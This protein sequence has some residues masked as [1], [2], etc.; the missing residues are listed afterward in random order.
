MIQVAVEEEWIA[1][2]SR[3]RVMDYIIDAAEESL[4][5]A[6]ATFKKAGIEYNVERDRVFLDS[7]R[8]LML[9]DEN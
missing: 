5:L 4:S 2:R 7:F 3:D 9:S 6:S 1:A 8:K